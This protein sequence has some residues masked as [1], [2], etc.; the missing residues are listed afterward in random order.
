MKPPVEG[1]IQTEIA[2]TVPVPSPDGMKTEIAVI[3]PAWKD[4]AGEI[5]LDDRATEIIEE[6]RARK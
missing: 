6:A 4:A 1:W 5:Y 3:V 2:M